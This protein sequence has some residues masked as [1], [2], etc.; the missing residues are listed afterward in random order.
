MNAF[1]VIS[2]VFVSGVVCW[3]AL[4]L[5]DARNECRECLKRE[6]DWEEEFGC[7]R[8]PWMADKFSPTPDPVSVNQ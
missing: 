4:E 8:H 1:K 2:C 5:A 7:F 6:A 3:Q